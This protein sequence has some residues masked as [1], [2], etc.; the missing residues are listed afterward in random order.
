MTEADRKKIYAALAAPFPEEAIERTDG[1]VTGRGYDTTGVRTQFVIDRLN[2]VL[3]VGGFRAHRTM[4]VSTSTSAKGRPVFDALCEV[5]LELGEWRDG[6]FVVFA[7]A[8][9]DGG[10]SAVSEADARKG[11]FSNALKKCAAMFGAGRDAYRGVLDDDAS[12]VPRE[13]ELRGQQS[14]QLEAGGPPGNASPARD[15]VRVTSKQIQAIWSLVRR[16]GYEPGQFRL[17]VRE[18]YGRQIEFLTRSE[19]SEV[20]AAMTAGSA[21]SNG[22]AR[23][24]EA[25]R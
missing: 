20:I 24:V 7:E 22:N 1:R 6:T 18:R 16:A 8:L 23:P 21:P 17:R 14:P 15:R 2:E 11:A 5:R 3:G 25:T 4:S 19:A 12:P 9:G 10:H 13:T